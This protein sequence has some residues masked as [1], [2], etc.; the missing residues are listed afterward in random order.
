MDI[1]K[2][3]NEGQNEY[4]WCYTKRIKMHGVHDKN[5]TETYR[6]TSI[7][8][9]LIDPKYKLTET[10]EKSDEYM[11]NVGF[12]LSKEVDICYDFEDKKFYFNH[13]L[14]WVEPNRKTVMGYHIEYIRELMK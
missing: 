5:D 2:I 13:S 12:W 4:Y 9:I 3:Y 10:L 11:E 7:S 8:D 1:I 14:D 6:T